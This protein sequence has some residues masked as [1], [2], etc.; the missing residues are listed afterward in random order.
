MFHRSF[1]LS[2]LLV[3]LCTGTQAATLRT[4]AAGTSP[5]SVVAPALFDSRATE[6]VVVSGS[7][8]AKVVSAHSVVASGF[9]RTIWAQTA[10]PAPATP[11]AAAT[12]ANVIGVD[13]QIVVRVADNPDLSDKPQRV[14]PNGEIRLP[15]IGRVQAGGLTPQQLEAELTSRYKVFLNEPDV[16][17]AV[18]ESRSQPVSVVGA[19][20]T[21]G[22]RQVDGRKSLVEMLLM[23]GGAASDAGPTVTVTRRL[24]RGRIPLLTAKDDSSGQFSTVDI[25]LRPL[26][27]GRSPAMDIQLQPNDVITVSKAE[28]IFV[29]GEVG[30]AGPLPLLR[31]NSMT[32]LEAVSSA[33]GV[34]RTAAAGDA[35]ILRAAAPNQVRAE[36]PVDIPKILAGKANDI[37]LNPGDILVVP[38]STSKRATTRILEAAIQAGL[39]IGTY[40]IIR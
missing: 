7:A 25:E 40:G 8:L 19:V 1:S 4:T 39:T 32:I 24:E 22:V 2:A 38:D 29:I 31:G 13:D 26:L 21:P 36:T 28:M 17:V 12:Q 37:A 3:F 27:E 23:A 6:T 11:I 16:M 5:A 30:K 14:D 15:M 35:R 18:L 9:S 33:G 10:A 20:A 34:L